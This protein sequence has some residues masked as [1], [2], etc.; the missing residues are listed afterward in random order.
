MKKNLRKW[1]KISN[2]AA[3]KIETSAKQLII[4]NKCSTKPFSF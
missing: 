3:G 1:I 4:N 2:F